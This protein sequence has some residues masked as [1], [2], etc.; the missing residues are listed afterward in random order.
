MRINI[1]HNRR[2]SFFVLVCRLLNLACAFY[3]QLIDHQQLLQKRRAF[4]RAMGTWRKWWRIVS[5][6]CSFLH[7]PLRGGK[8]YYESSW[9]FHQRICCHRLICLRCRCGWWNLH[10]EP[11]NQWWLCGNRY[12]CIRIHIHQC[13]IVWS[14]QQSWGQYRCRV[15]RQSFKEHRC[16]WR[17]RRIPLILTC[18]SILNNIQRYVANLILNWFSWY[19]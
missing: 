14:F 6:W 1:V 7:L 13:T 19:I 10:L 9:S 2:W 12:F 3:Q 8:V 16:W 5:H 18:W 4:H 11:W 17:H 15:R